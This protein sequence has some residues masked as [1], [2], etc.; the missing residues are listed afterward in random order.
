VKSKSLALKINK[1]RLEYLSQTSKKQLFIKIH[2]KMD[3]NGLPSG[4]IVHLV[5][6][7]VK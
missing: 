4:T 5:L 3:V 1:Q 7:I 6:P 2:D